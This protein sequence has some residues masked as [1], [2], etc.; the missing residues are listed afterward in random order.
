MLNENNETDMGGAV[1]VRSN[2]LLI[3]GIVGALLGLLV[4]WILLDEESDGAEVGPGGSAPRPT[5]RPGDAINLTVG[6][7]G[8]VRQIAAL[9]QR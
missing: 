7:I 4:A 1:K 6:A 2:G 9:R 8:V 5:I 3:G